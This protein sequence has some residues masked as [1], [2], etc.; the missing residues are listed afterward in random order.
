[1]AR[2]IAVEQAEKRGV[3]LEV[4]SARPGWM[5]LHLS[6]VRL[7]PEGVR[8]VRASLREVVIGV[9]ATLGVRDVEIDGG[10]IE[11]QGSPDQLREQLRAWRKARGGEG[12][13]SG[14]GGA[15]PVRGQGLFVEWQEGAGAPAR[16]RL[17]G[18]RFAREAGKHEV[19][20]ERAEVQLPFGKWLAA[21]GAAELI[22]SEEGFRLHTARVRRVEGNVQLSLPEPAPAGVPTAIAPPAERTPRARRT[23][24]SKRRRD[25]KRRRTRRGKKRTRAAEA[26]EKEREKVEVGPSGLKR[27]L[28]PLATTGAGGGQSR[29]RQLQRILAVTTTEQAQVDLDEVV[30][31]LSRGQSTLN[32]GPAP[33][34]LTRTKEEARLSFRSPAAQED[35]QALSID[36]TVPMASG[37]VQAKLSGGPIRLATLGVREGDFGLMHVGQT[38]LTVSTEGSL[39]P[40]G[41]LAVTASGQVDGLALQHPALAP[42][43][44]TGMDVTWRGNLR[45]DLPKHE[46]QVSDGALSIGQARVTFDGSVRADGEDLGLK[47]SLQMPETPCQQVFEAAPVA[48][49]PQ[50]EGLLL[51]GSIGIASSVQFDT[52]APKET[53]VEWELDNQCKVLQTP[54]A[55]DPRRFREPFQHVVLDAE[56]RATEITTGPTTESWVPLEEISPNMATALVVCEDSRFFRHKGFDDKAIRDSIAQNLKAGHFVRGASTLTMQ[57]AKNLYLGREKTIARKLQE[58][59]FTMLLEER[60][61]KEDILELY[62][63]VVEFGPGVYGIRQASQHYFSSHPGELSLGQALFFGSLLP[64][65]KVERFEEDGTLKPRYAE[66]LHFLMRVAHKIKRITDDELEAGTR[67][68]L[69]FGH[70]HEAPEADF[71]FGTSLFDVDG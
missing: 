55:V 65:P 35:G 47:L 42:E 17:S 22:R 67:E 57:L 70:P 50:L 45:L 28:A 71:L 56:G 68:E 69:R 38:L 52:A 44:L 59:A 32:L 62:L 10:T 51:G 14:G 30:L 13:G 46:L 6:G 63:N 3:H 54:Q 43:P 15:L 66:H 27:L 41:L 34:R 31:Q 33:L 37:T 4:A 26:P 21:D 39:S 29:V 64:S 19:G 16:H 61:N 60:L 53:A 58:A 9:T 2:R 18:V 12:A 25:A 49:L 23:R 24:A 20:F 40:E 1:M 8:G 48:L 5:S 7:A 11:L 36:A